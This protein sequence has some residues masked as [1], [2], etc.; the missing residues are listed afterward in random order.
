MYIHH[1]DTDLVPVY[2]TT[3]KELEVRCQSPPSYC[4]VV[5]DINYK[6]QACTTDLDAEQEVPAV[7]EIKQ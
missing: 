6:V 7:D 3:D 5:G 4:E 2:S 1:V